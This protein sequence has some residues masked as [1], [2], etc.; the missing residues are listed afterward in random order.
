ML[1]RTFVTYKKVSAFLV[2]IVFGLAAT[3]VFAQTIAGHWTFD[4]GSG[5]NA[6]DSSGRGQTASLFN[7]TNWT[8]GHLGA[9]VAAN[10]AFRQYVSLPAIDLS[11]TH[12]VTIAFWSERAYSTAGGHAL[13]ESTVDFARSATG[14]ALFPDDS[15]CS[16]IQAA[17]RGDIGETANCYSQPTSGA[18]HHFALV[19]DKGQ[20]AG[21][22]VA[23]YVDGVLQNPTRCLAAS[24]N[25][26]DF[27]KNPIYLFSR[28]GATMYDS[29][30]VDDLRVYATALSG[31]QVQQLYNTGYSLITKDIVASVDGYR[32]M[33]TP[34]FTTSVNNELL[35][36]FV[37]YDG[38]TGVGET[39]T[40]T[41]GG[42]TWTLRSRSNKQ[43]GTSE[44]WSATAPQAP[45]TATVTS[46]PT[47]SGNWH[48]SL[49]VVGFTN[50]SGTGKVGQ[51]NAS[52]GAPDIALTSIAAGNWVF[53]VGN[54]WD[55]AIART[56]ASGQLLVHQRVDT[57]VGDTYWVQSIAAPLTLKGNVDIHD[58]APTGDRWNYAAV[59][60]VSNSNPQ[61][62]LG[63]SPTSVNFGKVNV[64][65]SSSQKVTLTNT[66][67]ASLTVSAV[68]VSGTGFFVG[69]VPTPFTL[70]PGASQQ[71]TV[72]FAPTVSGAITGSLSVTSNASNPN[73]SVPLSGTGAT[74]GPLTA[75]PSSLAFGNVTINTTSS[76]NVSVKNT[77]TGLVTV[78]AVS[79]S[80]SGFSL[81]PVNTPF[82]MAA[83]TS[84]TLTASF[85][86]T[87][88]GTSSGTI[89][90][91]SNATNPTLSIPLSGTGIT[92][93]QH[94]VT[95]SWTASTSQVAG[96][97]VYRASNSNG[98]FSVLN[99]GL[100]SATTYVDQTVTSGLTYYY[101]ATAVDNQGAESIAS[102]QVS[103]TVP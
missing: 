21:N 8:P 35:V 79:I 103:A 53:A 50:A 12:A 18:W 57:S 17:M 11:S 94:Q 19:L 92:Q 96:Y 44:I 101:Y 71:L 93:V 34:S 100:I 85:T 40:V 9:A 54:D 60:I 28:A 39:A 22:Q 14:F 73:L 87:L 70:G 69:T 56:P 55:R 33:T 62:T 4:E 84:A 95:L 66:G 30:K 45:F 38:P 6:G 102:N 42:L 24:T 43:W 49:T 32:K 67:N 83:G 76:L 41:G 16:G 13:I 47:A 59:E 7:G 65:T 48:G 26:N 75:T 20:S 72:T 81:T 64:N 31:S 52:S 80:G 10:S 15:T 90:V 29:G 86:P 78:S 51:A 5:I 74:P 58:T 63:A 89:T 98:P 27:G 88:T 61:G 77:G 82:T 1:R 91:T 37:A 68:S 3:T 36:A 25:T 23:L 97:K 46:Q 2:L 99:T